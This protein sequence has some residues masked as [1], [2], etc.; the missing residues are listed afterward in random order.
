MPRWNLLWIHVQLTRHSS[1]SELVRWLEHQVPKRQARHM[2]RS[3][4]HL[5]S[6]EHADVGNEEPAARVGPRVDDQ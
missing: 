1:G 2:Q 4:G 3:E 6:S 5:D